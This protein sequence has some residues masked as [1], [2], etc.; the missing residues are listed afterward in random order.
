MS[1]LWQVA[2][3]EF[4]RN[5]WKKSFLIMLV[6]VPCWIGVSVGFGLFLESNRD[7]VRSV[8]I[9]D[10]AGILSEVI[11]P[12]DFQS[13]WEQKMGERLEF[14]GFQSGQA[15]RAA[16]QNDQIQVYFIIPENYLLTRHV[17][18]VY[19][20]EPGDTAWKQLYD[21]LRLNLLAEQ[22]PEIA[23]LAV[24]GVQFIV[25][26]IDGRR[27]VPQSQ[28]PTFGL[29]FP[30]YIAVGFLVALIMASGYTVSA[31]ADEKESR[32][33]EIVVTTISPLQFLGG[34][35]LGI[36]AISLALL[37][38]WTGVSWMG[39]LTCRWAGIDWFSDLSLDW[40]MVMAT[41]AVAIPAYSLAVALMIT[42]GA[43]VSTT[44]EGQ[45]ISSIFF[46]L[47]FI[48]LYI[49]YLIL[50]DPFS[51]LAILL[52]LLPFTALMTIAF[53]SLFIIVPTWQIIASSLIQL[54]CVSGAIWLGSRAFRLGMLRYGK[55]VTL[56][57]V[58]GRVGM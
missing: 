38:T 42:I 30:L 14:V 52:S 56:Q 28:G 11:I 47:H 26:S 22:S 37:L 19:L 48:P 25:R 35:L 41:L 55:R 3:Y 21:V 4:R 50:K 45:T 39:I 16:L 5:V 7:S 15:A 20:E 12:P 53:R 24:L 58:L 34:K 49:S 43:V 29:I 36:V 18:A 46:V 44:Q 1:K 54:V 10:Q 13:I 51:T 9:V 17:E 27:E 57:Q 2:F 6:S 32:T 31:V 40:S 33:L 23:N 8:G